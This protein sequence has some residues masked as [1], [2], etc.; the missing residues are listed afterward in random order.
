MVTQSFPDRITILRN[1]H[2]CYPHFRASLGLGDPTLRLTLLFRR[3]LPLHLGL[4]NRGGTHL[5]NPLCGPQYA[6]NHPEPQQLNLRV[7]FP[8]TQRVYIRQSLAGGR[9][10]RVSMRAAHFIHA[11][12]PNILWLIR[13]TYYFSISPPSFSFTSLTSSLFHKSVP[14]IYFATS[15]LQT[16]SFCGWKIT[17]Y[18]HYYPPYTPYSLHHLRFAWSFTV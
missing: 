11:A 17:H 6:H 3:K 10:S 4:L 14:L 16:P 15:A 7:H 1:H 8:S 18:G 9:Q 13:N 2:T 5:G 12:P